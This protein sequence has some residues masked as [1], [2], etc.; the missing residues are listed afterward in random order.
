MKTSDFK[1]G[2]SVTYVPCHAEGD[3]THEDCEHGHVTSLNDSFVFVA[4]P[5]SRGRGQACDPEDLV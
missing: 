4:F 2:Q 5:S 1:V 3:T